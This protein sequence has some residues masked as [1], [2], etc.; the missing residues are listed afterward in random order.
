MTR[1]SDADLQEIIR[2]L[3]DSD[4][5]ELEVETKRF[6]LVVRRSDDDPSGWTRTRQ[7]LTKPS[8]VEP[9]PTGD[10]KGEGPVMEGDSSKELARGLARGVSEITAPM[11]G[12]FYRAPRPGADPFVQPG[13]NVNP[14]AVVAIIEVMK[15]MYSV[16]AGLNGAVQEICVENG[17]LVQKGQRLMLIRTQDDSE[18][19]EAG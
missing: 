14:D 5:D 18:S 9:R 13:S 6:R 8:I 3:D 12:T 7:T 11:V 1:L 2:L 16:V 17:D 4:Y 10:L 19:A 15:L